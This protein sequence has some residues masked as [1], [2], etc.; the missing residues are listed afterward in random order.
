[1]EQAVHAAPL[2]L[3]QLGSSAPPDP[4]M[5][6]AP[7]PFEEPPVVV[8][9]VVIMVEED[10]ELDEPPALGLRMQTNPLKIYPLMQAM[11]CP[12]SKL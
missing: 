9:V 1:L 5:A 6:I 3:A 11:H 8:V 4:E 2:Y 12:L 7:P 10:A